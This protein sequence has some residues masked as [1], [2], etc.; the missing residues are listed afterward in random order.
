MNYGL[1]G[2]VATS[3]DG[4]ETSEARRMTQADTNNIH[5]TQQQV[6][7]WCCHLHTAKAR[8]PNQAAI[9]AKGSWWGSCTYSSWWA[10]QLGTPMRVCGRAAPSLT[11]TTQLKLWSVRQPCCSGTPHLGHGRASLPSTH[12]AKP[13]SLACCPSCSWTL[14]VSAMRGQPLLPQPQIRAMESSLPWTQVQKL[15]RVQV[16]ASRQMTAPQASSSRR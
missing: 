13:D 3:S 1:N 7:R 16:C 4:R 15:L 9:A 10:A 12:T 8:L 6:T 5:G 14:Q 2:Q 11:H